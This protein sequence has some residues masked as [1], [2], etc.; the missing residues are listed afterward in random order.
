MCGWQRCLIWS[1][2]PVR[3]P[4][5]GP[6]PLCGGARSC[7]RPQ[8][9]GPQRAHCRHAAQ[10]AG[11]RHQP[12]R[13]QQPCHSKHRQRRAGWGFGRDGPHAGAAGRAARHLSASCHAPSGAGGCSSRGR[14]RSSRTARCRSGCAA[15]RS[16][17]GERAR[18]HATSAGADAAPA[19]VGRCWAC[20]DARGGAACHQCVHVWSGGHPWGGMLRQRGHHRRAGAAAEQCRC[21]PAGGSTAAPRRGAALCAGCA[22]Q[23]V[24]GGPPRRGAARRCQVAQPRWAQWALCVIYCGSLIL[25]T[26][27]PPFAACL[28]GPPSAQRRSDAVPIGLFWCCRRRRCRR[29]RCCGWRCLGG[30]GQ[31]RR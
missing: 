7:H 15:A 31:P 11:P 12:S 4:A 30:H 19:D 28:L 9:G 8:H 22:R 24:R 17:R 23:R 3:L 2:V 20:W 1:S 27:L 21:R 18:G 14:S 29:C 10:P 26:G 6:V 13:A 5:A 25:A 16:A